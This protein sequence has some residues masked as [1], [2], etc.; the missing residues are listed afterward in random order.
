MKFQSLISADRSIK[1]GTT[2]TTGYV[3]TATDT[4]GNGAWAAAGSASNI[5]YATTIGD[6]TT[7]A[8][9]LTHGLGTADIVVAV[10]EVATPFRMIDAT[11]AAISTTQVTVTFANAPATNSYRVVVVAVGGTPSGAPIDSP[12]FTGT[13][14]APTAAVDTNTVQI[15]TT[16]Y[17]VGQGYAKLASPNFTGTPTAPTSGA[18]TNTT[19]L[20]TTAFVQQEIT[21]DLIPYAPHKTVRKTAD[22]A[23]STI[24]LANVTDLSFAVTT[25]ADHT[26]EFIVAYT[27]ATATVGVAFAVTCPALG[28]AGYM[29]YTVEI[30]RSAETAIGTAPTAT[31]MQQVG[32]GTASGD[33]VGSDATPATGTP[34]IAHIKGICSNPSAAGNIQL[35]HRSETATTTTVLKGSWG[36]LYVN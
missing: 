10:R 11:V 31:N 33:A 14:T 36:R 26:F 12:N 30:I 7:T 15:A 25:G 3:W 16:A 22:Q 5:A 1:I 28:A 6:G 4:A 19:Q 23:N 17:V 27:S 9:T 35:Q 34:F 20:A 32:S 29:G 18:G 21:A 2:S 13:P 8:F 24:T